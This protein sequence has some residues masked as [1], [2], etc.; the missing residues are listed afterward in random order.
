VTQPSAQALDAFAE[1]MRRVDERLQALDAAYGPFG[2]H[3]ETHNHIN[4]RFDTL[5][6]NVVKRFEALEAKVAE[7]RNAELASLRVAR[8]LNPLKDTHWSTHWSIGLG[9]G[10]VVHG[11]YEACKH[12]EQLIEAV[13]EIKREVKKS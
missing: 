1:W 13:G 8:E 5:D 9:N 2:T 12:V 11:S 10:L 4:K 6:N 7:Q 3:N